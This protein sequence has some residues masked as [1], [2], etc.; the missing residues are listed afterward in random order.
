[1][2]YMTEKSEDVA[3]CM[4][5]GNCMTTCPVYIAT[6]KESMLARG[7]IRLIKAAMNGELELTDGLQEALFT[8]LNCDACSVTCPPG[9]PVDK[10]I[11]E[12]KAA[13]LEQG[14]IL[15]ETQE[16]IRCGLE[17]QSNPFEQPHEER[18]AWLP[19]DLKEPRPSK[20]L[21]HAGCSISYASNRTG[22]A[23]I[24]MLQK[25]GVDFTMLGA[26]ENCCGDP[27]VRM[28]DMEK[29][30]TLWRLNKQAFKKLG[31]EKVVTPCA[32]CYSA[33]KHYYS[34]EV[35]AMHVVQL[36]VELLDEGKLTF[37]KKFPKKVVYFDGC[38]IGRHSGTYD[39]PRKVLSAIPG[40]ALMEMPK[41]HEE[42]ACCG[43]PLLGSYPD[44]AR[45]IAGDRAKEAQDLGADVIAVACPTCLLNLKE[46]ARVAGIKIDI[47]D[48]SAIALRALG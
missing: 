3:R 21:L 30:E 40:L 6:G 45:K 27:Y 10:L 44:L 7:R 20:I 18:G 26:Q 17:R 24:R 28:G 34:D 36:M 33:F 13:L 25:A 19:P 37:D 9:V 35:E 38:D 43:G 2:A 47:Q 31:V 12:A 15:P 39:E 5:C 22:K 29:A 8:C 23:V 14:K 4:K 42:S 41:H 16:R 11:R 48:V 1:M 46:G 32:G